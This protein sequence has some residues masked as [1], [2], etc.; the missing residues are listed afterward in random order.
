MIQ[1]GAAACLA[2]ILVS[3]AQADI[4]DGGNARSIGMG[5]AGMVAR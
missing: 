4:V 1:R 3:S 5:G 2:L